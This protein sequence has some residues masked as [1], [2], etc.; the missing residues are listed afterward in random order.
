MLN[1]KLQALFVLTCL[2]AEVS[3][4]GSPNPSLYL[5]QVILSPKRVSSCQGVKGPSREN[6]GC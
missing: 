1:N 2:Y 5:I 3:V 6:A 4:G